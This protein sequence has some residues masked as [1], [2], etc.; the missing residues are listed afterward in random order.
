MIAYLSVEKN[1]M[2][3]KTED[4]SIDV[5]F[6]NSG[7]VDEIYKINSFNNGII[8]AEVKQ[9]SDF[10]YVHSM[11]CTDINKINYDMYSIFDLMGISSEPLKKVTKVK[12]KHHNNKREYYFRSFQKNEKTYIEVTCK[13]KK[14]RSIHNAYNLKLIAT[15]MPRDMVN[16][17]TEAL[18]DYTDYCRNNY[19]KP[20]NF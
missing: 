20:E 17:Y 7:F 6:V 5:Y 13:K 8:S 15:T 14:Y 2:H 18:N 16:E 19:E 11:M 4:D 3:F 9:T 10:S 12:V 1:M